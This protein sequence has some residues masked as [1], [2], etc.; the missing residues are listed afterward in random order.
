MYG[1]GAEMMILGRGWGEAEKMLTLGSEEVKKSEL[2]HK[3][4]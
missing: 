2:E 3:S 1:V 4:K